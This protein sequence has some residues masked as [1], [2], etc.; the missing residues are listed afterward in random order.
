MDML[1]VVIQFIGMCILCKDKDVGIISLLLASLFALDMLQIP[2]NY[3]YIVAATYD[4]LSL[5]IVSYLID[6]WKR[7][8]LFTII[9]CSLFM[10]IYEGLS[11]Y[12]TFIYPYRDIIQWWM[13]EIM[14]IILA[15]N[16][17]WRGIGYV[18]L[19][20]TDN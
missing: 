18:K 7:Y 17:N 15:W 11:Y 8:T 1:I 4:I 19:C 13:V 16:C 14:F 10:N 20:R 3:F 6:K 5:I 9:L 12:Q 2:D